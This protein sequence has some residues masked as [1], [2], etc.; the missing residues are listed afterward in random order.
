MQSIFKKIGIGCFALL[1]L[2]SPLI[3]LAETYV[4][5]IEPAFPPWAAVKNGQ[6]EGIAP[7]AI[8][9]MAK[10]QDFDVK[11]KSLPFPSLIP[12]LR[13]GK[14]DILATGLTVSKKR[15]EKIAFTVPWWEVTLDTLVKKDSNTNQVTALCCGAH[16][17][18]QSGS[19]NYD[20][21]K[22]NLIGNDIDIDAK[23]Y[24]DDTVGVHDVVVGRLDA[25]FV[26]DNTARKFL[27]K[28]GNKIR[29][30]GKIIPHP[31]EVYAL[32]VKKGNK[33]LLALLNKA[34]IQLYKSGKWAE[35][36][37][38]YL[39]EASVSK[40]PGPMSDDIPSYKKP[41]PGLD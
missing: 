8:R 27:K 23:T 4:V 5:G 28:Q 25:Y 41:V 39:P 19:T 15:A 35:V 32:G 10:Q 14:I 3:A 33:E 37:H 36:I 21:L 1:L 7:D 29:L 6:I 20:W 40:V 26:D 31:P 2:L 9:A 24:P 12:A 22:N 18:A 34:E 13:A 16:V 38:K 17:G 11:F 30:A